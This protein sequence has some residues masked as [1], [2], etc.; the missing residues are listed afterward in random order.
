MNIRFIILAL[1]V[2]CVGCETD[3]QPTP[4]CY[5]CSDQ[6]PHA[7]ICSTQLGRLEFDGERYTCN[8]YF[9]ASQLCESADHCCRKSG[10]VV[11][12]SEACVNADMMPE[13]F[14]EAEAP[15]STMDEP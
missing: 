6:M 2:F 11:N 7:R 8:L 3:T 5:V 1:G 13:P 15:S 14:D 10:L 9:G 12:E 4:A